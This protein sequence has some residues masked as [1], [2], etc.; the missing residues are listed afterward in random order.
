MTSSLLRSP[1]FRGG[2]K[3]CWRTSK[4]ASTWYW[5]QCRT[6]AAR[7]LARYILQYLAAQ[8]NHD[9]SKAVLILATLTQRPIP[10]YVLGM[11][12]GSVRQ[13][14]EQ[15]L[16][17]DSEARQAAVRVINRFGEAGDHRFRDLFN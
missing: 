3:L 4:P 13:V 16:R 11:E 17:A 5:Q 10:T 1:A 2:L 9:A 14:L 15:A 8:S 12:S 6:L 7:S